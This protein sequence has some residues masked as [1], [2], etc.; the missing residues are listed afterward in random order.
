MK[1]NKE[2]E[3][4][5]RSAVRHL[6]QAADS[7]KNLSAPLHSFFAAT[8]SLSAQNI[9]AMEKVIGDEFCRTSKTRGRLR[10]RILPIGQK[11]I[12]PWLDLFNSNGFRRERVLRIVREPAPN[13]FLF[14]VLLRRLNDW[15]PQVQDAAVE[16]VISTSKKTDP[17]ILASALFHLLPAQVEW[18]RIKKQKRDVLFDLIEM[19]G[20]ARLLAERVVTAFAG[21]A[22][23]V[24]SQLARK[25]EIDEYLYMVANNAIQPAVRAKAFQFLLEGKAIWLEGRKWVWTD[26]QY[27]EGRYEPILGSRNINI[28]I[29]SSTLLE[30]ASLD[31][32]P[33]VRRV[34]GTAII[35]QRKVLGTF[36]I[37][38]ASRL[39]KDKYPSIAERGQFVL[40]RI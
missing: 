7:G 29:D 32:S 5:V 23:V 34:A 2:T 28:N 35:A 25:Q 31:P 16:A 3:K 30:I 6:V 27:C 8:S 14:A 39:A 18:G 36:G 15:V 33:A 17:N 19:P 40:D 11:F 37:K 12:V 4:H 21:P 20:V 10:L 38:I 26:K 24:L 22:S 1:D 9:S 13:E